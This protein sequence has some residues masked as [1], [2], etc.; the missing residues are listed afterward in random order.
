MKMNASL[1]RFAVIAIW[2]SACSHTQAPPPAPPPH[3]MQG[4]GHAHGPHHGHGKGGPGHVHGG[5][6]M[7]DCG[8]RQGEHGPGCPMAQ[9]CPMMLPDVE[10]RVQD[11]EGGA[12]LTFTTRGDVAALRER[13][14][15]LAQHH[16]HHA[17]PPAGQAPP[18]QPGPPAPASPAADKPQ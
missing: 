3:G 8:G 7:H 11:V 10:V 9:M 6:S 17:P 18:A 13:V 4:E 15:S 12:S 5:G 1:I 14:R 16:A 2:A